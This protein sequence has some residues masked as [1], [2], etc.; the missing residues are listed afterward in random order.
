LTESRLT[1]TTGSVQVP[2]RVDSADPDSRVAATA[3]EADPV[4]GSYLPKRTLATLAGGRMG[5]G[6][7]SADPS[8]NRTLV[9]RDGQ[10]WGSLAF[11]RQ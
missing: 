1:A 6:A 11:Q 9:V 4:C 7:R 8:Q 5:R 10:V 3:P 2:R